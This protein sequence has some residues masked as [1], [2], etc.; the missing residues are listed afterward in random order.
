MTS[1][2]YCM[3]EHRRG[4]W[5]SCNRSIAYTYKHNRFIP[6][7]LKVASSVMHHAVKL[8]T[9]HCDL[10]WYSCLITLEVSRERSHLNTVH[11]ILVVD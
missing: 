10:H 11:P 2:L 7:E 1:G 3:G 6:H 4:V 5:K 8:I 9:I